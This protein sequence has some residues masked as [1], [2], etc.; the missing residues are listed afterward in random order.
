MSNRVSTAHA[1]RYEKGQLYQKNLTKIQFARTILVVGNFHAPQIHVE[2]DGAHHDQHERRVID[3]GRLHVGGVA[4]VA[5]EKHALCP[6]RRLVHAR[7][8][9]RTVK[10]P[11][12]AN[13]AARSGV[14]T[15]AFAGFAVHAVR[16]HH[17]R[18]VRAHGRPQQHPVADRVVDVAAKV[19][20]VGLV[21]RTVEVPEIGHVEQTRQQRQHGDGPE[22]RKV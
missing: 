8:A 14:A 21:F 20:H 10:V 5:Q 16:A 7:G 2:Q 13:A 12:R 18:N 19:A 11:P 1:V 4:V 9:P 15:G 6:V 22:R 17:P 3:H